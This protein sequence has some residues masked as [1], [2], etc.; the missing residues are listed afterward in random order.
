[1]VHDKFPITCVQD[2][3]IYEGM[4]HTKYQNHGCEEFIKNEEKAFQGTQHHTNQ[5]D[6]QN[7]HYI[8]KDK[9]NTH[10]SHPFYIFKDKYDLD[11]NKEMVDEIMVPIC[12][13]GIFKIIMIISQYE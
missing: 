9:H 13:N 11:Q 2:C 6:L 8:M 1:M 4:N 5:D 7:N 10:L 3:E 12:L